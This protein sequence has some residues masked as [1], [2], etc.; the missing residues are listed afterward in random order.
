MIYRSLLFIVSI[1]IVM[2]ANMA[3][4]QSGSD[5]CLY[6][7]E[8]FAYKSLTRPIDETPQLPSDPWQLVPDVLNDLPLYYHLWHVETLYGEG[9]DLEVWLGAGAWRFSYSS[10]YL[11]HLLLG[12]NAHKYFWW[13]YRPHQHET[14]RI[15]A[16][17]KGTSLI[18]TYLLKDHHGRIWA[19]VMPLIGYTAPTYPPLALFN[20]STRQFELVI[21]VPPLP[22]DQ[23]PQIQVSTTGFWIWLDGYGIYL[24]DSLTLHLEKRFDLPTDWSVKDVTKGDDGMWYFSIIGNPPM[25]QD[26]SLSR[27]RLYQFSSESTHLTEIELIDEWP[28]YRGLLLD[29]EQRLWLGTVGF[30]D[31]LGNWYLQHPNPKEFFGN[32]LFQGMVLPT[33]ISETLDGRLWYTNVF[34]SNASFNGSAWYDPA[35]RTGCMFTNY[36]ISMV[37][38]QDGGLWLVTDGNLYYASIE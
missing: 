20:E 9:E 36:P 28:I 33:L 18:T 8:H 12:N 14:E 22:A 32:L 13:V 1:L 6:S 4:F 31:S 37:E 19:Q 34:D 38:D 23:I 11:P 30:R 17:I 35:T 21:G 5:E 27:Q 2:D 10:Y 16:V 29:Q 26:G 25:S 24:L 7:F 15:P 3:H